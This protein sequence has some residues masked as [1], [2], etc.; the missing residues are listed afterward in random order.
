MTLSNAERQAR[1]KAKKRYVD[2]EVKIT[3]VQ[4]ERGL[5]RDLDYAGRLQRCADYASWRWD[6][7]HRGEV[8]SL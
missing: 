1:F 7:F 6:A 2:N 5:I 4:L 3:Q 8:A